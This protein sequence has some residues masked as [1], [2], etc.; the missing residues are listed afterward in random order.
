MS[1]NLKVCLYLRRTKSSGNFSVEFIANDLQHRL[2]QM[3]VAAHITLAPFYSNGLLRRLCIA[4]HASLQRTDIIHVTGDIN[5][6]AIPLNPSRALVTILDC[7]FLKRPPGWKR[8][9]LKAFWLDLP[10]RRCHIV[11]TISHDAKQE[12]IQHTGCRPEKVRVIPVAISDDYQPF[13]KQ[14]ND[15]CPRILQ[16]GT[17][18]NKNVDR[19]LASLSGIQCT[20]VIV[21]VVSPQLH[22]LIRE[23]G[24]NVEQYDRLPQD[25]LVKHYRNCD[26]VSFASIHE[27]FGMPILEGNAVGRPVITSDCSSMPEVAGDAACLVNPYEVTSIRSGIL[28]LLSDEGYRE[29]LVDAGYR[30]VKRFSPQAIA[31]MYLDVYGELLGSSQRWSGR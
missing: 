27:G 29:S 14:F 9:I 26:I 21:G 31:Q 11:T 17:A 10:V 15:Q 7:G 18:P 30:N 12:I 1:S 6:A 28:R 22:S 20:L 5:F 8:R 19:L 13:P 2:R 3:G 16:I 4:I 23:H 25:E 24:I